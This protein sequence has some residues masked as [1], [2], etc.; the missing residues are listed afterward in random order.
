M[1]QRKNYGLSL[2]FFLLPFIFFIP[3]Y[4]D[5]ANLPTQD[6]N[7]DKKIIWKSSYVRMAEIHGEIA[8]I[9]TIIFSLFLFFVY[10]ISAIKKKS[11]IS[12]KIMRRLSI[13]CFIIVILLLIVSL[14]QRMNY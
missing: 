12:Y 6:G 5:I 7:V 9:L 4:M 13:I 1:K 11:L 3:M 10:L 2:I 8:I 14:P